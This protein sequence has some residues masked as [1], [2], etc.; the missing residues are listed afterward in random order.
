MF[1]VPSSTFSDV[2]NHSEG[3]S[4]KL[5]LSDLICSA[6]CKIYGQVNIEIKISPQLESFKKYELCE[7]FVFVK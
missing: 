7:S 2:K 5:F 1:R 3:S 6:T 4:K